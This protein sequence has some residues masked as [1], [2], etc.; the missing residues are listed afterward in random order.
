MT[1]AIHTSICILRCILK[2]ANRVRNIDRD[3]S[4]TAGTALTPFFDRATHRYCLI[5]PMNTFS[6][7]KVGL[8]L[9]NI[10]SNNS[11]DSILERSSWDLMNKTQYNEYNKNI[12]YR[13]WKNYGQPYC[14]VKGCWRG[15]ICRMSYSQ[16]ICQIPV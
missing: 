14:V 7:Q 1:I 9:C 4:N 5:A 10:I 8:A 12:N 2:V 11:S 15:K 6:V 3:S 16:Y 13:T